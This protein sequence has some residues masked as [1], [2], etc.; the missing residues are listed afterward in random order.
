MSILVS[1]IVPAYN[2]G[3][4]IS[5]T[6][7]SVLSQ[8]FKD[9]ELIIVDDGSKDITKDIIFDYV[10]NDSRIKYIYQ[11]NSGS[12]SAPRNSG[13]ASA[14][15]KY[16][17]FFDADDV[18]SSDKIAR[19]VA[20]LEAHPELAAVFCDY[21]NFTSTGVSS[22]SHFVTCAKLQAYFKSRRP[23][24]CCSSYIV[25]P[26]ES[27]DILID[28]NFTIA[29]SPMFKSDVFK[30]LNGYNVNLKA[31]EDWYLHF[32]LFS[33]H[34]VAIDPCVGFQRRIHDSNMSHNKR[35]ILEYKALSRR[36][37]ANEITD[38]NFKIRLNKLSSDY[39][40]SLSLICSRESLS[41]SLFFYKEGLLAR[42]ALNIDSILTFIKIL[43]KRF[44]I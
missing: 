44:V 30:F 39:Y 9:F 32:L 12:C 8:N 37:A 33:N 27:V 34:R 35:K 6:I 41:R 4:Y 43:Y 18:M 3:R 20:I 14:T 21:Q 36:M 16:V 31:S 40:H 7:D 1:I 5:Q 42:K 38:K 19:Q 25:D 28:E 17:S 11:E 13:F 26:N 15:G 23:C 22:Q 29:C 10:K 2:A 24:H